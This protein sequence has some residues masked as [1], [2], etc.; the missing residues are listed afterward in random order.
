MHYCPECGQAC[1]CHGDID[2][3]VVETEAYSAANCTCDHEGSGLDDDDD[4]FDH[5][6]SD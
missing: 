6:G 1:H 5:G 2:D 3:C 4:Y